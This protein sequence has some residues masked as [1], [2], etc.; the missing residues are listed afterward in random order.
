MQLSAVIHLGTCLAIVGSTGCSIDVHS[1]DF[2]SVVREEQS[3][4]VG[5]GEV[6]LAL[7][8]FD[9]AIEV[10][11]WDRNEVRVEIER[12]GR[13]AAAA[14]ALTVNTSQ[15]GNRV[16]V[17]AQASQDRRRVF[18][19]WTSESVSLVVTA[20]RELVLDASTDDGS[21]AVTDLDGTIVL[22]SGDGRIVASGLGGDVRV[23][24][25]DGSIRITDL[26]GRLEADSGDGSIEVDGRLDALSVRSGDGSVR[27][28][29]VSGS[30]M[31]SDWNITTGDGSIRLHLPVAFGAEVDAH[32]GDGSVRVD[33]IDRRRGD[34][35]EDRRSYRGRLG[36]GGAQLRLRTGDGS[37][38]LM[39]DQ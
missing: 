9:G 6:S 21:I 19:D 18:G 20:P 11:S 34:D 26:S 27:V 13:D 24:T 14:E 5:E 30:T 4:S 32:T 17:E 12:R 22:E 29:A 7:S 10:R 15:D 2:G 33:G 8:T 23:R 16:V 35:D 38:V 36:A 37:I 39:T 3:F 28:A 1:G 25:E 31:A